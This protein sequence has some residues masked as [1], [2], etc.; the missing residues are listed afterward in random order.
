MNDS[1]YKIILYIIIVVIIGTISIQLY[2]NYKN[3][4][5][6]KQQ[7]ISDVQNSLDSAVET[8]YANLAEKSTYAFAIEATSNKDIFDADIKFD[9]IIRKLNIEKH[10]FSESDSIRVDIKGADEIQIFKGQQADSLISRL[11]K[12]NHPFKNGINRNLDYKTLRLEKPDS[13]TIDHFRTLTSKV[14]FSLS[15]DSLNLAS[16]DSLIKIENLRKELDI[17]YGLSLNIL[18][19]DSQFLNKNIIENSSLSALSKST[20]LPH[21]SSLKIH[22]NNTTKEILKRNLTGISLSTILVLVVISCLFYLLKIIKHQKQLAEI[23]NDFISNITHEFKT[24]I[25]TIGVALESIKDFNVISD[26]EKTNS[27]IEMSNNQLKKL[28][29]MVEKLLETA[30]LDS[31]NLH[32]KKEDC[33]VSNLIQNLVIKHSLDLEE[34]SL[35]FIGSDND[36]LAKIDVFH[37]ENA[38]N[39]ILDNAIKYG[40]SVIKVRLNQNTIGFTVDISDNGNSL[41]KSDKD[42]IFE[43]FY[44]IPKGNTHDVKG[45]GIGLYYAKKIIEKHDGVIH[46]NLDNQLT[47]FKISVPNE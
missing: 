17:T 5:V 18:N 8:Y 36:V 3:Y 38:I 24:P 29:V 4:G 27:Y 21:E 1:R 46:L 23:K 15:Q 31:E 6:N 44:R 28:N 19:Q 11:H 13:L 42:K 43:K 25:A 16:I 14:I 40:G 34:K 9:S 33:N 7:L 22:F 30:S 37:F 10:R 45:F 12:G 32:L 2:W 20:Y 41:S 26:K 47:T 35:E 39:N